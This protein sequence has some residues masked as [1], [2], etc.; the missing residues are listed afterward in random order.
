MN[1]KFIHLSYKGIIENIRDKRGFA[2]LLGFPVLFIIIFAFA[3]AFGSGSFLSG[4]SIPYE[5]V[6]I[7][8]DAG[9]MVAGTDNTTRYVNYGSNFTQVLMNTTA[10]NSSTHLFHLSN[11]SHGEAENLLKSRSID[12]PIIIPQNFSAGLASEVNNST[13]TAITSSVGQQ[14]IANAANSSTALNPV[15]TIPGA[16]VTLPAAGNVSSAL[17][18]EGDSGYINFAT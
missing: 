15:T 2:L 9:V 13:R 10:E 12:A 6:V 1:L 18:I 17:T 14:A 4:G 7:N 16:S 8:N 3:F 5:V 11:A